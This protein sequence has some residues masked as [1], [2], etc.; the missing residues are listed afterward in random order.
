MRNPAFHA[1]LKEIG[2][3]HDDKSHDYSQDGD[4]LSNLRRCEA[5]GVPAWKGVLVRLSDK[6]SRLEQLAGGKQPKNES[7]RDSL[8]DSAVY[9]L[10]AVLL[11]DEEGSAKSSVIEQLCICGYPDPKYVHCKSHELTIAQPG[12]DDCPECNQPIPHGQGWG[13]VRCEQHKG[14]AVRV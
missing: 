4:P 8:I 1:L 9:S 12:P 3:I 5:F 6:W 7:I 2:D 14:N 13:F 11:L 10:L